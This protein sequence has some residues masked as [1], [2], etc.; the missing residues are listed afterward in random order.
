MSIVLTAIGKQHQVFYPVV[1]LVAVYVVNNF[2][3]PKV[4][5]K[6]P[7]HYQSVLEYVGKI[8]LSGRMFRCIDSYVASGGYKSSL[9][10]SSPAR[11]KARTGVYSRAFQG[12]ENS[13]DAKPQP[14][15][16]GRHAQRIVNIESGDLGIVN[17]AKGVVIAGV[18]AKL[19]FFGEMS[20]K[21]LFAVL[22]NIRVH[23]K[24]D[25]LSSLT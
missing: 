19:S 4:A 9:A 15:A 12:L 7:L 14:F 1:Y 6:M 13:T 18:G 2:C 24:H 8:G 20:L 25:N 21:R 22:A 23:G 17:L 5:T 16:Y 11:T 10:L 3:L